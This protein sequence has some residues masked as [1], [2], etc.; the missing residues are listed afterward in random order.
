MIKLERSENQLCRNDLPGYSN[1]IIRFSDGKT[2][3]E[4]DWTVIG[5]GF[6]RVKNLE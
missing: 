2:G 3:G 5:F 4:R 1:W 6:R